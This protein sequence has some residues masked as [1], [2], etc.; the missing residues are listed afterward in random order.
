MNGAAGL[1]GNMKL[2]LNKLL[3]PLLN[4]T[5]IDKLMF[6]AKPAFEEIVGNASHVIWRRPTPPVKARVARTSYNMRLIFNKLL[7]P[8]LNNTP[9]DKLMFTAKPAFKEIVGNASHVIWRSPTPP[10]KA[11]VAPVPYNMRLIFNKL[12]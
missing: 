3:P 12:L 11:R 1:P 5:P 10:V 4:D 2:I 9:I 6:T 8:L 7:P